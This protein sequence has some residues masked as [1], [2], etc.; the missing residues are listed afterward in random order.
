MTPLR[1]ALTVW[2]KRLRL[3]Y[4]KRKDFKNVIAGLG[5]RKVMDQI[6]LDKGLMTA[7]AM[8]D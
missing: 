7:D 6:Y 3:R 8:K 2:R 4:R 1:D 5:A